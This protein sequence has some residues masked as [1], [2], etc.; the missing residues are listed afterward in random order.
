VV[1]DD[2]LVRDLCR[3]ALENAGFAVEE[4]AD[5]DTALDLLHSGRHW[6]VT[7]IDVV[8]PGA[9]G[10]QIAKQIGQLPAHQRPAVAMITGNDLADTEA[11]AAHA[12]VGSWVAKPFT[13]SELIDATLD[14]IELQLPASA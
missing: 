14:S 12:A 2:P 3:S 10:W 9:D 8:L 7:V 4:A 1:D 11:R 5:G 6:D 13:A